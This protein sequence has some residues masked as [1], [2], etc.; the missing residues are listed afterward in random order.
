[1]RQKTLP[2]I[3][4]CWKSPGGSVRARRVVSFAD[5]AVQPGTRITPIALCRYAGDPQHLGGLLVAQARVEAELDQLGPDRIFRGEARHGLIESEQILP[6][7][8]RGEVGQL[9]V[10]AR[11]P[12]AVLA[13]TF[14]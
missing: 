9:D 5:F 4:C 7:H 10:R 8:R 14:A 1:M 6:G 2:G 13:T 12:A 3:S 11:D